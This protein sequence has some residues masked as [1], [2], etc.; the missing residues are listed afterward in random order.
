VSKES[1]SNVQGGKPRTRIVRASFFCRFRRSSGVEASGKKAGAHVSWK[2]YDQL[3]VRPS[4][5]S[6]CDEVLDSKYKQ[7]VGAADRTNIL[8][9]S[10]TATTDS[11][12]PTD[13][14]TGATDSTES[15]LCQE[16]ETSFCQETET[17]TVTETKEVLI[18]MVDGQIE[19]QRQEYILTDMHQVGAETQDQ[20]LQVDKVNSFS[21]V[22][23]E[24]DKEMEETDFRSQR[25]VSQGSENSSAFSDEESQFDAKGIEANEGIEKSVDVDDDDEDDDDTF[26]FDEEQDEEREEYDEEFPS[27]DEEEEEDEVSLKNADKGVAL[28]QSLFLSD[29]P[30]DDDEYTYA[31]AYDDGDSTTFR[32]STFASALDAFEEFAAESIY[33]ASLLFLGPPEPVDKRKRWT[34]RNQST[35]LCVS[36]SSICDAT[37]D[38]ATLD[39]VTLDGETLDEATLDEATLDEASLDEPSL[40]EPSLDHPP[41]LVLHKPVLSS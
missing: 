34:T 20:Q 31:Y 23:F 36:A 6:P 26:L 22:A 25:S 39:E 40:D 4:S 35:K 30:D 21:P 19:T 17:L 38:E 29:L 5:P 16:G 15:S 41:S 9:A 3:G 28:L 32:K 14:S 37:L 33:S 2:K 11:S 12:I 13:G 8:R 1:A 24:E 18:P 27:D 7:G 10:S